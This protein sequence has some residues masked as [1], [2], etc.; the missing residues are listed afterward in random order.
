MD[1]GP[2]DGIM[3]PRTESAIKKYQ[4]KN[5]LSETG[6]LDP[7]TKRALGIVADDRRLDPEKPAL[8]H[9]HRIIEVTEPSTVEP[10]LPATDGFQVKDAA[11]VDPIPAEHADRGLRHDAPA[12][13]TRT[14]EI[15]T[16]NVR[17]RGEDLR[18]STIAGLV[19][20]SG[21]GLAALQPVGWILLTGGSLAVAIWMINWVGGYFNVIAYGV[22]AGAYILPVLYRLLL[23]SWDMA[24]IF[25]LLLGTPVLMI[26]KYAFGL[27]WWM[28]GCNGLAVM[29]LLPAAYR[30]MFAKR[31]HRRPY[32]RVYY[33]F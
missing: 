16:E 33:R 6:E 11:K 10:V 7:D 12:E 27:S 5:E 23:K 20:L 1:P 24:L 14:S 31:G 18:L 4:L 15:S 30:R 13:T 28:A 19:V 22:F 25:G 9:P 8:P 2:I 32:G 17:D 3:G 21:M 26:S 29:T